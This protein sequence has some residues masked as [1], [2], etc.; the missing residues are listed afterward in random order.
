MTT[1]TSGLDL[2]HVDAATRVQDD[3]YRHVNGRWLAELAA[4]VRRTRLG[5]LLERCHRYR[6]ARR[7]HGLLRPIDRL[8]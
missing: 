6:R 1:A 2:S 4:L 3:L 7:D 8:R 5:S